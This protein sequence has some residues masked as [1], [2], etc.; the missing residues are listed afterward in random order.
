[1]EIDLTSYL[2]KLLRPLASAILTAEITMLVVVL[3]RRASVQNAKAT[4]S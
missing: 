2:A 4:S 3:P 1:M